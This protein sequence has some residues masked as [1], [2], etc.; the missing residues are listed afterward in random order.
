MSDAF[1]HKSPAASLRWPLLRA[2][3]PPQVWA[4]AA[5]VALAVGMTVMIGSTGSSVKRS[6]PPAADATQQ[7]QVEPVLPASVRKTRLAGPYPAQ[8]LRIIDGDTFEARIPIWFG[9]EQTVL[10]RLR[11]IDTPELA[12]RCAS[13]RNLAF[14]AKHTLEEFLRTGTVTLTDVSL[15]KYAGRVLANV[16]AGSRSE[17]VDIGAA[18]LAGGY[19]RAYAGKARQSW[20]S[21]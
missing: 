7:G 3:L 20:C 10:V 8:V 17:T 4:L 2:P 21:H 14:E 9:Q 15:D 1:A 16:A 5:G 19:A 12:G 11:G 18:L 6:G 13:E